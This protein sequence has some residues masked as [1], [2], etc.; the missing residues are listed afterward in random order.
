[1]KFTAEFT[2]V[3]LLTIC[4]TGA[5]AGILYDASNPYSD[6]AVAVMVGAG[7]FLLM[8]F[9]KANNGGFGGRGT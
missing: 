1:M 8:A 6:I 9:I 5:Y 7:L 3:E 4:A 2:H